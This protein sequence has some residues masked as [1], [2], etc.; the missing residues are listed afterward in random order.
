MTSYF[1]YNP[2]LSSIV[3]L[4]AVFLNCSNFKFFVSSLRANRS[5]LIL[6]ES[7]NN[8]TG[9]R[10]DTIEF[11]CKI[12]NAGKYKI[13]FFREGIPPRLIAYDG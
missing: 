1:S 6:E 7:M 3:L 4:V 10:G 13:A 11:R 9:M 2:S 8:I 5:P 12:E